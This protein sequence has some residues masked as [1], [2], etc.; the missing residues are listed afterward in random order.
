MSRLRP[1]DL[2]EYTT[3]SRRDGWFLRNGFRVRVIHAWW[4]FESL[5]DAGDF[6]AGAFGEIGRS[7]GSGLKRPRLA[8]NVAI[9]HRTKG[10]DTPE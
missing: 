1:A 6:L 7:V 2:P 10:G 3:W 9:Y 5:E 4:T 8:Y